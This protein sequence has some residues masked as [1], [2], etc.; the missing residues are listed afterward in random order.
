[1]PDRELTEEETRKLY[2]ERHRGQLS[3]KAL[4]AFLEERTKPTLHDLCIHELHAIVEAEKEAIIQQG[5]DIEAL[6][7]RLKAL[8]ERRQTN[9]LTVGL[10]LS[11][12]CHNLNGLECPG[13]NASDCI[14]RISHLP[15]PTFSD[16]E[17][18][19]IIEKGEK[20]K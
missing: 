13:A 15:C 2:Y 9:L 18:R 5:R 20:Q 14:A 3:F 19:K 10:D 7:E 8:E 4:E 12:R 17:R 1:M 11:S 6:K 16:E